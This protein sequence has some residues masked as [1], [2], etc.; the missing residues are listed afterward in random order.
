MF[1]R[2]ERVGCEVKPALRAL[3]LGDDYRVGQLGLDHL[4]DRLI[5]EYFLRENR[6]RHHGQ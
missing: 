2:N 3:D 6:R 4:Y 1:Q 5:G